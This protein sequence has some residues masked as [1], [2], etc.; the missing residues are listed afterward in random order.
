[1]GHSPQGHKEPDTTER[2][3]F[4]GSPV[5]KTVLPIQGHGFDP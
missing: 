5:V 2:L 3:H 1:M 4:P